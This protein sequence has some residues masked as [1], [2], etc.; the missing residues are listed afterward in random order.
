MNLLKQCRFYGVSLSQLAEATGF[1][2]T[3]VRQVLKGE[4]RNELI[5]TATQAALRNRKEE[6]RQALKAS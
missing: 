2:Y 3:Y 5:E 6:L 4:R 1:T